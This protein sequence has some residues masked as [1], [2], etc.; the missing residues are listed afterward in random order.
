MR[1][2]GI[3]ILFLCVIISGCAK[4]HVEMDV[5]SSQNIIS[6]NWYELNIDVIV[7]DEIASDEEE[8]SREIIQHIVNNDFYNMRFSFDMNGYPNKVNINVFTTEKNLQKDKKAYSFE[9]VTEFNT[10][11]IEIQ[12]N[13]KDNPEE[14]RIQFD[15]KM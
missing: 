5:F 4:E 2:S 10:E 7:D 6:D 11:N 8:C 12:N 13:I 1:R 9:Y 14:F 3:C 15:I